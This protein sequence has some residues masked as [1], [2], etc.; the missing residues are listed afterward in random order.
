MIDCE[1]KSAT[2]GNIMKS[3]LDARNVHN[4]NSETEIFIKMF[5]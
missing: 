1:H 5:L 2:R 4:V 3:S